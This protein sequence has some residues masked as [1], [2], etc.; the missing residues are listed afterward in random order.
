MPDTHLGPVDYVI[1]EF[2]DPAEIRP[3]FDRLV[4]LVDKGL[5]RILDL[6]FIHG[7]DG[8]ASTIPAARVGDDF[9]QFDGAA[10]GLLDRDDL[11]AVAADLKPGSTAAVLVYEDLSIVAVLD[12]WESGGATI[13]AEGPVDLDELETAAD[14]DPT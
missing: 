13:L 3:G 7:I 11:D 1:V 5:I 4:A 14:Q 8:V 6:E 10:S 12:A 2:S 9:K